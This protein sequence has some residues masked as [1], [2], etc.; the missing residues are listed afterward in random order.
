MPLPCGCSVN[1]IDHG[2]S[3]GGPGDAAGYTYELQPCALHGAAPEILTAL[4]SLVKQD[5]VQRATEST[6]IGLAQAA[7]LANAAIRKAGQS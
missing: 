2:W 1:A 7:D 4:K 6:D 3:K 5:R